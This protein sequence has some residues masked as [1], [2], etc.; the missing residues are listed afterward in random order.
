MGYEPRMQAIY[1]IAEREPIVVKPAE[2]LENIWATDVFS[3]SKMQACLPKAVYKSLKSTIK[4]D[5]KL[6]P[7]VADI[8]AAAMIRAGG[9]L[10]GKSMRFSYY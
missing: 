7:S 8:V 3:L 10:G 1:Q 9:L 2:T 4:S 5:A 6:D